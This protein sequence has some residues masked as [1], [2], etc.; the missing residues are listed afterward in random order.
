MKKILII[1]LIGF[2]SILTAQIKPLTGK[3]AFGALR[4]RQLGPTVTSG[5]MTD[6]AVHPEN[7]NIIYVGAAGGGVWK[8]QNG[9]VNFKP[10]FDKYNSSIGCIAIDPKRPDEIIWVG[11]GETW[12]RNS[13][14]IGDGLYKSTDGG[15]NWKKMGFDDSERISSIVIHP[16]HPDTVYVAVLGHLWGDYDKR[17]VYKT[18]DGGKTWK[19]I[20]SGLSDTGV[21]DLVMDP[22]HPDVLYAA[23][24]QFRRT[25]WSFNSGGYES[26]LLKSTDGGKT[27]HKIHNGFPEGKLGRIAIAVAPSDSN[28]LYAVIESEQKD[29]SGLYVSDDAGTS[30]QLVNKDFNIVV[31]PFYFARLAVDPKDKNIVAKAGFFAQISRDG[32]KTFKSF[33]MMHPDIHDIVFDKD[34]TDRMYFA[35]DG[36]FYFSWDKGVSNVKNRDLNTG[37]YYFVSVDNETPYNIYGGLQDNGSWMVPNTTPTGVKEKDWTAMGGG[38]GFRVF[39]HPNKPIVYS[40]SQAGVWIGRYDMKKHQITDI[41]PFSEKEGEKLRFNWNTAMAL[42]PNNPDRIYIGSQYLHK[43]DDTG[44][45]WTIISPDL[46]TNDKGKQKQAESGGIT[47]DNSGAENYTDIFTIAESPLDENVIWVG[48]DD[49]LVQLT[50]DGGKHWKN[51]TKNI[52][53]LPANSWVYHIEAS[54][55]DKATA[56]AVF[57]RHTLNDMKTYVYKT[58]DFGRTWQSIV[59]SEIKGFARCIQEDFIKKDLLFLGTEDGLYITLNGG[60]HWMKFENNMPTVP[61]HYIT[62]QKQTNDLVLATHGRGVIVIDDISPLRQINDSILNRDVYIFD[63]P[64]FMMTERDDYYGGFDPNVFVAEGKPEGA[65]FIY[66]LKKRHT[67]GK[68]ELRILDENGKEIVK[69]EPT[70]QKGINLVRW[71]FR[72]K[73]PKIAKGHTLD[74]SAIQAPRVSAGT[75]VLELIKGKKRYT[76]KFKTLYDTLPQIPLKNR[77]LQEKTVVELSKMMENLAYLVYKTDKIIEYAENLKNNPDLSNLTAKSITYFNKLKKTLVQTTG[78]NY[79]Q[80]PE[81]E[82][83]EKISKLYSKIVGKYDKPG[84]S[85]MKNLKILKK[86]L[87]DK[88]NEFEHLYQKYFDK[89]QKKALKYQ[90]KPLQFKTF[91]E[92]VKK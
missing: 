25:P 20:L 27:W 87:Q 5:R 43:S 13:V 68:M 52:S 37:Q 4:A 77:K 51:V 21:S 6:I 35:T 29:K 74:F 91:D 90:I 11:T 56:Y 83:R 59:T 22:N 48:T 57:D 66:Y 71:Y 26:K 80:T 50:K 8:S 10:V 41:T 82:L 69:L 65:K 85:Q 42:S 14:S 62:L 39:R 30:W 73:T 76:K 19:K 89:L 70:K 32:G 16:E 54:N 47:I 34:N 3:Q 24:W 12:T 38:D 17:G 2:V 60:K 75:Y 49:G 18:T 53:G 88:N 1:L 84:N 44:L 92:F 9:G 45:N 7:N 33:G 79:T 86:E 15:N 28:R 58:T 23:L 63:T 55:F 72:T 81:P 36:G 61:V 40:E 67:F 64:D 46:T 78:D 31:R